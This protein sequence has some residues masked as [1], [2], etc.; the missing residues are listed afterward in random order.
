MDDGS[1]D[2][3]AKQQAAAANLRTA[4]ITNPSLFKRVYKHTFLI[5]RTP[6][7][8]AVALDAAIEFWRLLFTPPSL[9]WNTANTPWLDWWIEYLGSK[10]KKTV[11]KDMWDQ[12]LVFAQKSL[13]DESMSWWSEDGAWPGV[14]DEFV[15]YVH[16]K[17]GNEGKMEI[18]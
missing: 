5:A 16:E 10:W 11:N 2:T 7:Q 8:K 14:L 4:L 9:S 1:A 18:E 17:R 3:L 12:T 6:G 13:D 15:I